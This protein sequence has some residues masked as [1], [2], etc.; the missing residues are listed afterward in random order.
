MNQPI[1]LL[2]TGGWDSTFRLLDLVLMHRKKVQP[3]YLV[4]TERKSS[5]V[6]VE[7][8][9][10]IRS[11]LYQQAPEAT[12]LLLPTIY[13]QVSA[14]QSNDTITNEFVHLKTTAFLGS[15]Y[16]YLARFAHEQRIEHLELSVHKDDHAQKFLASYVI[17][18][19]N[20]YRLRDDHQQPG[21][22]LFRYF[23]FPILQLTK[24]DMEA[25]AKKRGFLNLLD[26]TVFCHMPLPSGKPCG[27]CN[28]CRYTMEEGL[29][30]RVPFLPRMK[31]YMKRLIR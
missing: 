25:F 4:S 30:R 29:A 23:R 27:Y 22:N 21:L 24:R 14:I 7:T 12:Q 16:D 13:H 26:Q 28:P 11:Q 6:E 2:W 9:D 3:Y 10:K 8:M 15:Q 5:Q 17:K 1:N 19:N 31:F 18:E 20:N